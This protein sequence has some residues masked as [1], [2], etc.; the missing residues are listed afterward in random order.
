[1]ENKKIYKKMPKNYYNYFDICKWEG[2][3]TNTAKSVIGRSGLEGVSSIDALKPIAHQFKEFPKYENGYLRN[4]YGILKSNYDFWKEN[5]RTRKQSP[6][7]PPRW[8]D[9]PNVV[10]I[11]IPFPKDLYE[12]FQGVVD[13]ANEMSMIKVTYR[14]MIYVAV[15]EFVDR[16][17]NLK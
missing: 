8:K 7:R 11:N 4:Q 17:P 16:R 10:N 13:K 12:E 5:G 3:N 1:M 2:I 6:G 9:N 14:D 15:R